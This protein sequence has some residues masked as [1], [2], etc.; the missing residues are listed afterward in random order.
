MNSIRPSVLVY[1]VVAMDA[2]EASCGPLNPR[3]FAARERMRPI[4]KNAA[5]VFL[6]NATEVVAS[7]QKNEGVAGWCA[8][9]K[10]DLTEMQ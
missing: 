5:P 6:R 8:I 4:A 3:A 7:E 1:Q 9:M 2:Y 10:S